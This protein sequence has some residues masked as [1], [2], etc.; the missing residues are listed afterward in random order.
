MLS[1]W[2]PAASG[3][4]G[5]NGVRFFAQETDTAMSNRQARREQSRTTRTTR[6]SRPAPGRAPKKSSGGG[7]PNLLSRPYLIGVSLVIVA[8][9]VV[10]GVVASRS[11]GGG[12]TDQYTAALQTAATAL[13]A[14][15]ANGAKL[16]KDDAPLKLTEFEDFQCPFCL[17]YTATQEPTLISE[18]VKTGKLQIIYLN[19]P[20]L[21]KTESVQAAIA[22]LCAADQGGDKFWRYKDLL[23][24]AEAKAGQA[25]SEKTDVGRF[26]NANLKDFATQAGLDRTKF[27]TC[28][29]NSSDKVNTITDQTR[30]AKSFG[31]TGTPGFLINGA[32]FGTGTPNSL[33]DWRK[34]LDGVLNATPTAAGSASP[35]TTGT[36]ATASPA[37]TAAKAAGTP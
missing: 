17:K 32:P 26:S 30:Q 14:D 12:T 6:P 15:L 27:D 7:G 31:I 21:G 35:A 1:C 28:L 24:T 20:I 36:P 13:P 18:Y 33:D 5:V 11:G 16:G 23:F 4:P 37:A 29:D 22:G 2:N 10:L 8:L 25:D 19:L 34:V 3:P 9:A